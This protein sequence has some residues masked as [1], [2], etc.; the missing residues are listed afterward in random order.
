MHLAYA[1]R[2]GHATPRPR[3]ALRV[4]RTLARLVAAVLLALDLARVARD[5][6]CLLERRAKV[7]VGFEE[8]GSDAV[9]DG[10]RLGRY[11]GAA[12]V[13]GG[14]VG[15]LRGGCLEGLLEGHA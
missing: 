5:E 10:D 15:P 6:A 13:H 3:S 9:P 2:A 14:P 11:A 1:R 4:L 8:R 7:G 12:D